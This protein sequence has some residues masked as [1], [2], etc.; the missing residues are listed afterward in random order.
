MDMAT[1]KYCAAVELRCRCALALTVCVSLLTSCSAAGAGLPRQ[2]SPSNPEDAVTID[3]LLQWSLNGDRGKE[4]V[5]AA[6]RKVLKM[7]PLHA[8]QFSGDGP[9]ALSDGSIL[10][11]AWYGDLSGQIDIGVASSPCVSPERAGKLIGAA[12]EIT[13]DADGEDRGKTYRTQHAGNWIEITTTPSTYRCVDS[14]NI[15]PVRKPE[16]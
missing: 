1:P 10:T 6:L 12:G 15:Y 4:K 11:F 8:Q 14:I 5:K 2:P 7:K 9:T 3:H 13:A 16:P